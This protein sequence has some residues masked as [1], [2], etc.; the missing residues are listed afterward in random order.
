MES[1]PNVEPTNLHEPD[2]ELSVE[3]PLARP[4]F[5]VTQKLGRTRTTSSTQTEKCAR[6]CY[7]ISLSSS[8][9]T[10]LVQKEDKVFTD[11]LAGFT[12]NNRALRLPAL[13]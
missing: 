13:N 6:A 12:F 8:A 2:L 11:I 5:S 7:M 1:S 10:E 4:I 9:E 3:Q